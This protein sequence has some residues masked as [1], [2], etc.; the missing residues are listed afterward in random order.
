[1]F[2]VAIPLTNANPQT[3]S[4]YSIQDRSYYKK[5]YDKKKGYCRNPKG[6]RARDVCDEIEVSILFI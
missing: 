3:P 5:K 4:L 2:E 1:L 6:R